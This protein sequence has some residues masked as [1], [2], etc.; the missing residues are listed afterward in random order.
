MKLG[1]PQGVSIPQR[2]LFFLI[3]INDILFYFKSF[4]IL[5]FADD[6]SL[7]LENNNM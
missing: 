1:V 6:T 4:K 5:L 2:R 7:F 3:F